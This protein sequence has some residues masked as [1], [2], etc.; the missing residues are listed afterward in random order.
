MIE[1]VFLRIKLSPVLAVKPEL[2]LCVIEPV[3]YP[4]SEPVFLRIK[5]SSVL[6]V[7]EL[8]SR[9]GASASSYDCGISGL[10]VLM[11]RNFGHHKRSVTYRFTVAVRLYILTGICI[12]RQQ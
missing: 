2:Y 6:A 1:P 12:T 10:H 7:N 9:S 8:D 11:N 3:S 4:I 5:P